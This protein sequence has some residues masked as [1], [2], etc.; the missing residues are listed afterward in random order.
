MRKRHATSRGRDWIPQFII[1]FICYECPEDFHAKDENIRG[2]G[3][4]LPNIPWRLKGV[5][6]FAIKEDQ[7]GCGWDTAH[8]KGDEMARELEQSKSILNKASLKTIIGFL[9]VDFNSHDSFSTSPFGY[10][11]N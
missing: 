11:V 6:S 10:W 2:K 4:S 8:N 7:D 1:T 3:V 5:Q 9:Q